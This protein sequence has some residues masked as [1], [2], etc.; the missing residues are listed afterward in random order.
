MLPS[1]PR[2]PLLLDPLPSRPFEDTSADL[3]THAVEFLTM[4][5]PYV[6][7]QRKPKFSET[8][9]LTLVEEVERRRH[10]I[11]G[12]LE[13]SKVTGEKK[14]RA[15]EEVTALVNEVSR[16]GR[17]EEE[18][19]RKFKDLRS[20]VKV[21]AGKEQRHL[22][23]TGG[24]PSDTTSYTAVEE[25]VLRM[26]SPVAVTGL[27]LPD[28]Q[29]ATMRLSGSVEEP[30]P[31]TSSGVGVSLGD[32]QFIEI[33]NLEENTTISFTDAAAG[34]VAARPAS[35]L[36]PV[37]SQPAATPQP[38]T[39]PRPVPSQPAATHR[40]V[41]SQP[42]LPGAQRR[43]RRTPAVAHSK[44]LE[45]LAQAQ[46]T[47][48]D[49]QCSLDALVMIQREQGEALQRLVQAIE[50]MAATQQQVL[51]N[52]AAAQR[53]MMASLQEFVALAMELLKKK[54]VSCQLSSTITFSL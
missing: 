41:A 39:S 50:Q 43:R 3:F 52:M 42:P 22:A 12:R 7:H 36:H 2:E 45:V 20:L 37:A 21:K 10:I 54:K 35:T 32:S 18:C 5:L 23:G 28:S 47:Q 24:G 53:G 15:W 25:V 8:E 4:A 26:M 11:L 34:E 29:G 49:M 51:E 31:S 46:V 9:A 16:V 14:Q 27:P 6:K 1:Q 33:F 19:R 38:F 30:Q 17:T 40:P 13:G 48:V 44:D